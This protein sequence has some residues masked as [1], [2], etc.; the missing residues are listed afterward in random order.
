MWYRV[1]WTSTSREWLKCLLMRSCPL[2]IGS[3]CKIPLTLGTSRCVC[4]SVCLQADLY[5]SALHLCY[6]WSVHL[7]LTMLP[8]CNYLVLFNV[9]SVQLWCVDINLHFFQWVP[10]RAADCG[11]KTIHEIHEESVAM[12]VMWCVCCVHV[13]LLWCIVL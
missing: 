4:V 1:G 13:S 6:V 8:L 7:E 9:H 11:P 2:V 5:V 3:C 10:R 12:Q